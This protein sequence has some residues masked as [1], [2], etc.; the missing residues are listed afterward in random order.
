[1]A[2]SVFPIL[3][4]HLPHLDWIF[5]MFCLETIFRCDST[6][7]ASPMPTVEDVSEDILELYLDTE[8][9]SGDEA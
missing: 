7:H 2:V 9:D 4:G 1:M 3:S 6:C 8:D 5:S